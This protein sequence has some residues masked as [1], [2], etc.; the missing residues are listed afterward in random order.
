VPGIDD[1]LPLGVAD[2]RFTSDLSGCAPVLM[3]DLKQMGH[4]F[5]AFALD[6]I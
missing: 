2:V 3:S 6:G 1:P 5:A 4:L